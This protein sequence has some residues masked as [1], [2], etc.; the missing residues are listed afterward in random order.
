MEKIERVCWEENIDS[1]IVVKTEVEKRNIPISEAKILLVE[2]KLS[3]RKTIEI[4]L[5]SRVGKVEI[6]ENGKEA[7]EMF[8][9]NQYDM[10]LMDLQMPIMGGIEAAQHIREM[11]TDRKYRVPIIAFSANYFSSDKEVSIEV[12][13]DAYISKPFQSKT[14]FNLMEEYI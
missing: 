7:V 4:Y 9:N 2:D 1:C 10:I 14:L 3:N 5:R 6:A 8:A 12:G 13:M 11:E